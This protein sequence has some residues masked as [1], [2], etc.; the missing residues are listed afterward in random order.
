MDW[1]LGIFRSIECVV[2]GKT[3]RAKTERVNGI[4]RLGYGSLG[5][6]CDHSHRS[7]L[8]TGYGDVDE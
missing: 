8:K 2:G 1:C 6:G 3:E 5:H 4:C 7:Q